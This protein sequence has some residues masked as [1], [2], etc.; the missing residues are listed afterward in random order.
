MWVFLVTE[1]LFFGGLFLAYLVY[2]LWYPAEFAAASKTLDLALGATN[3]V[4]LI[5]SSLTVALAVHSSQQGIQRS[6]VMFLLATVVLGCIFLGIK[7]FEYAHKFQEHH[8]PGW[9]F[10]FEGSETVAPEHAAIFF[11]LYFVMTGVHAL[12]MVIGIGLMLVMTLLVNRGRFLGEASHP[13]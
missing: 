3:T 13:I 2:R 5:V 10:Q 6:T 7:G 11:S 4:V 8:V 9:G 12:H 1:I